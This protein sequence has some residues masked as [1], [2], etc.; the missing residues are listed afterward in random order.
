M[1]VAK[2]NGT[3]LN[4][5]QLSHKG[6][7]PVEDLIMV[8]GLAANMGFWLQD[9]TPHFTQRFR[10][11]LYDLRGHGRS[12]IT[13]S[14]YTP[15]TMGYDLRALMDELKIEKAHVIAHSFGG[16]AVL[17]AATAAPER[18]ASLII[19]DSHI[20]TGRLKEKD[21]NWQTGDAL[22]QA[23]QESGINLDIDHPYFGFQL[24]TAVARLRQDG[25]DIPAALEPWVRHIL[26]GNNNRPTAEKWLQLMNE[27]KAEQEL[28]DNDGLSESSLQRITCPMLA[29]YGEKSKSI[30]TGRYLASLWPKATFVFIPE[31]G[32]FFPKAQPDMVMAHCDRFWDSLSQ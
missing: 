21:N 18:F 23:L 11:T 9:Y 20:S 24:I 19:A 28:M 31:A 27:T 22:R 32:H 7:G 30:H 25:K 10:V 5:M 4:Y 2:I 1:P 16:V 29:I 17:K 12:A 26:A 13:E 15:E 8:H 14:G 3:T 6:E